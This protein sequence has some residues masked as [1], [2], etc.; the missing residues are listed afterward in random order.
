MKDG[1]C[2]LQ[3]PLQRKSAD[4]VETSEVPPI[5]HEVLRS[6]G[7]PLDLATRVFMESR[8]GHDFSR[9][10]VHTDPKAGESSLAV[11]A[12]AYT[13]GCHVIF[14]SGQ[15][16]PNTTEGQCL[17][18][19]ELAHSIQQCQVGQKSTEQL[20]ISDSCGELEIQAERA[21]QSLLPASPFGCT[22]LSAGLEHAAQTLPQVARKADPAA[23]AK[24]DPR[25]I[26]NH[27]DYIDNNLTRMQ[28]YGAEQAVFHYADG[29]KLTIGL[30]PRWIRPPL[31]SVD[32]RSTRSQ[33]G[34]VTGPGSGGRLEFMRE[35][36]KLPTKGMTFGVVVK[37]FAMPVKFT[38]EPT[39]GKIVPNHLNPVTAPT[40]CN[41]LKEAETEYTKKFAAWSEGMVEVLKKER[42]IIELALIRTMFTGPKPSPRARVPATG[43]AGTE[44]V[45]PLGRLTQAEIEGAITSSGGRA[46][47]L[48]TKLSQ[49]P[50]LG[51]AV[52]FATDRALAEAARSAGRV[53]TV[54][55]PEILFHKL[56][57]IGVAVRSQTMMGGV[58]GTEIRFLP[59]ASQLIIRFLVH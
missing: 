14:A 58:L 45:G 49:A 1:C 57:L 7:Q 13:V 11:N 52:S 41:A 17:L 40:V 22:P 59:Q 26:M 6:P 48:Y 25:A 4:S 36:M 46:V 9:V 43:A 34:A 39:S 47:E 20:E 42:L 28:F 16:A 30:I 5:V 32:Y 50:A 18:A 54:R 24:L 33:Y 19:H 27:P 2:R 37:K 10:R 51:R 15:Y 29:A 56:E 53:F 21:A 55:I 31:E 44:L 3:Q 23:V 35:P 12:H 8:F 38:V